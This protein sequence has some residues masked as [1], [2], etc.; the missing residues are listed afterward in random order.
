[1]VLVPTTVSPSYAEAIAY[2]RLAN[3]IDNL[4]K[5][6]V[7]KPWKIL[8]STDA[9]IGTLRYESDAKDLRRF[10]IWKIVQTKDIYLNITGFL[11]APSMNSKTYDERGELMVNSTQLLKRE[12]EFDT[13]KLCLDD[14]TKINEFLVNF[15]HAQI[16]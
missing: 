14:L 2:N 16:V 9:L 3:T 1:M 13:H 10:G 7:S 15:I 11:T 6:A 8:Q 12:F 4:C 5:F